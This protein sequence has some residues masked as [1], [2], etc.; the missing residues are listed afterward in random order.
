MTIRWGMNERPLSHIISW[1]VINDSR[2]ECRNSNLIPLDHEDLGSLP[3]MWKSLSKKG[4]VIRDLRRQESCGVV[5]ADLPHAKSASP[6][7]T[8]Q[9][10]TGDQPCLG[11]ICASSTTVTFGVMFHIRA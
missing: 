11:L 6:S 3:T 8:Y 9:A 2:P 4:F 5:H 1:T 10:I 7:A